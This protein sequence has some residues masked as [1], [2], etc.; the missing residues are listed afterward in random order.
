MR[1]NYSRLEPGDIV[2]L[3]FTYS[4]S[5]QSK[6]RPALVVSPAD[7]NDQSPDVVVVKIT[8]SAQINDFGLPM[9][10]KDLT[11]GILFKPSITRV[12]FPMVSDKRLISKRI[13]RVTP[14]YFG[15][16]KR[17]LAKFFDL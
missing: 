16:I 15:K 10:Q 8:S 9:V 14:E 3:D 1:M 7:Y 11:D 6:R 4:D 12:D 2:V 5:T 13:G 17:L